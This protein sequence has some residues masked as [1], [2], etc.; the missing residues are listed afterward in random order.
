MFW[1]MGWNV[2]DFFIVVALLLGPC[3]LNFEDKALFYVLL[4][5]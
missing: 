3:E 4:E 2:L 5:G 1:K